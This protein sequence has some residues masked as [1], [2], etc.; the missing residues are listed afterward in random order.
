MEERVFDS[1]SLAEFDGRDGRSAY[2][3]CNGKV[4]DVTESMSWEGGEHY[5]DHL[6]GIDLTSELDDAPHLADVLD[7]FPIVGPY[8]H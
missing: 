2:V 8:V 5:D 1:V 6:A 4:Y 7:S 3:A